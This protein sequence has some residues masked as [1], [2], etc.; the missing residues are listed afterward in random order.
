MMRQVGQGEDVTNL[1]GRTW[2]VL[3]S[4]WGKVGLS[5]TDVIV[6]VAGAGCPASIEEVKEVS[7]DVSVTTVVRDAEIGFFLPMRS[8]EWA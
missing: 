6:G 1:A 3:G 4:S 8:N 7:C 5:F 2:R